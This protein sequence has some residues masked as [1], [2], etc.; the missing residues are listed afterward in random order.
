VTQ[1]DREL[2]ESG[3]GVAAMGAEAPRAS[4][5]AGGVG[6]LSCSAKP[7]TGEDP[8]AEVLDFST[9]VN[10]LG[11]PPRLAELGVLTLSLL[12]RYPDDLVLRAR[13]RLAEVHR[14]AAENILLGAG[15]TDL[16]YLLPRALRPR[17][18]LTLAPCPRHYWRAA[19]QVGADV[20]GLMASAERAFAPDISALRERLSGVD[21]VWLASPNDPTGTVLDRQEMLD[22]TLAYPRTVFVVDEVHIEYLRDHTDRTLL[23]PGMPPNLVVLR[24]FSNFYAVPG[25]RL[26]YL[27]AQAEMVKRLETVARPWSVHSLAAAAVPLLLEDDSYG[28]RTR[29]VV[30]EERDFLVRAV[31]EIPG[32]RAYRTAAN[33]L[34][35]QHTRH[36]APGVQHLREDLRAKGLLVRDGAGFRGLDGSY[37]RITI[38][39]RPE[40]ERFVTVLRAAMHE[41]A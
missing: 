21:L 11:P 1:A 19:E 10:P 28:V 16:V 14:V 4:I 35:I 13:Q 32:L 39:T 30:E 9:N 12:Q 27:G 24:S 40:N 7:L 29:Q 37:I 41:R 25:L 22:L 36:G 38:R 26:G 3:S 17:R 33:F 8:G 31:S 6:T 2:R 20:E 18:A 34:L 15:A 23:A 5:P